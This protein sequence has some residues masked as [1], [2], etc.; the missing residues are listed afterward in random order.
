MT[1]HAT[2]NDFNAGGTSTRSRVTEL[3]KSVLAASGSPYWL[4]HT[5]GIL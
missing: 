2:S 1:R 3:E 4:N 5:A